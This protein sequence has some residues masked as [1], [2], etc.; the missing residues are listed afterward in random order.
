MMASTHHAP[1]ALG[2]TYAT[3]VGTKGRDPAGVS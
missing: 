3:M 2:N 1:Y